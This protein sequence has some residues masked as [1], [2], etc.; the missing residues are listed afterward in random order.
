MTEKQKL[1]TSIEYEQF[2]EGTKHKIGVVLTNKDQGYEA[3]VNE[4]TNSLNKALV[5]FYELHKS[6]KIPSATMIPKKTPTSL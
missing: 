6:G 5:M 2:I 3:L 1:K 4:M